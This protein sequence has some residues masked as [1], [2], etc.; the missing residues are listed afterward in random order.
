MESSA[1][2]FQSAVQS[3][4]FKTFYHNQAQQFGYDDL[5]LNRR[6]IVFSMPSMFGRR[7]VKFLK[8]FDQP[9]PG[10][11]SIYCVSSNCQL[12][13]PWTDKHSSIMGLYDTGS[14][15]DAVATEFSIDKPH[16]DLVNFWQYILIVNNGQPEK[17][18]HNPV[19]ANMSFALSK[20]P[21]YAFHGLSAETV[22]EYLASTK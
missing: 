6:V 3:L 5:F 21:R 22:K 9:M 2:N 19:K 18:W 12:I 1:L 20:N 15:V 4:T 10:I 11:N 7:S 17:F 14:F 8:E 13:G 16:R